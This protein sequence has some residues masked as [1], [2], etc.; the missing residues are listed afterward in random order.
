MNYLELADAYD[1]H[2][3]TLSM[4]SQSAEVVVAVLELREK[5]A[6][7]RAAHVA[8]EQQDAEHKVRISG[9]AF[10]RNIRAQW[11]EVEKRKAA[12]LELI[13]ATLKFSAVL[14]GGNLGKDEVMLHGPNGT[15]LVRGGGV[16]G[17]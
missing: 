16:E 5:A 15:E 4:V 10:E 6:G 13:A 9:D 7:C 12:A 1:S 17:G 14:K 3:N 8:N 2:A 11:L